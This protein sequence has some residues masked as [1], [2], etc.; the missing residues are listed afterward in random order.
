VS[1]PYE[2]HLELAQDRRDRALGDWTCEGQSSI[3]DELE[4]APDDV[5]GGHTC[6]WVAVE[7]DP[8]EQRTLAIDDDLL[9]RIEA[10][11][12]DDVGADPPDHLEGRRIDDV[13][14]S[15]DLL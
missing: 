8:D 13:D 4:A 12:F 11:E 2:R 15:G 14:V 10:G 1:D 3:D 9:D 5:T 6:R 7:P